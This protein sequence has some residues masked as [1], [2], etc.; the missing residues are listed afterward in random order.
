MADEGKENQ[1]IA[2]ELGVSQQ[3]VGKGRKRF[4]RQG[5]Q[6]LKDEQRPGKPKKFDYDVRLKVIEIA[7]R[8]PERITHW[9]TRELA[10]KVSDELSMDISHMSVQRILSS[11][12]LKHHHSHSRFLV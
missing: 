8:K 4:S 5:I 1:Q 12:D 7:C 2:K 11:V 10:K 3:I 6:G 9:S